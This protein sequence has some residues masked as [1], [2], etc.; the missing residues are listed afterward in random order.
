MKTK[1]RAFSKKQK[2]WLK[3]YE[4]ISGYEA[5]YMN[6]FKNKETSW[7]AL[8]EANKYWLELHHQT[9]ENNIERLI[10]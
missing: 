1:K 6:D 3:D 4:D 8:V 5:M 7:N 10:A 9:I 2:K